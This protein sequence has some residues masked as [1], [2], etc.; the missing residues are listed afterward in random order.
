MRCKARRWAHSSDPKHDVEQDGYDQIGAILKRRRAAAGF[1]QRQLEAMTG[2]DQAVISRLENGK[3][4]GLRW[5]RF[6][7]LVAKLG[8]LDEA[9]PPTPPP[10]WVTMGVTPPASFQDTLRRQGLYPYPTSGIEADGPAGEG[11]APRTCRC[12]E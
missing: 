1:T 5:S 12:S 6:A 4:Y 9:K 7:I 8:G 11:T 10:W 3:Q 2:I